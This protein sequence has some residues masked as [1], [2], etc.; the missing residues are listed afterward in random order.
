M[1]K[2]IM[3]ERTI[4]EYMKVNKC[5]RE[6][7]IDLIKYDC[8]VEDG[9]ETEYDLTEEQKKVVQDMNRKIDH[10]KHSNVKRERKPNELKE[11]LVVALA[12]YL[13]N[14]C[15]FELNGETTYC[16][17]VEI[18][19]KNRMIHFTSGDKEFDL[20]LIE[21]RAKKT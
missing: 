5:S 15:E 8:D 14:A 2:P 20:Q 19:N 21:K 6:E 18:T 4:A 3:N 13:E 1:A 16:G 11:A 10:K 12:D 17:D 7:A 9:K